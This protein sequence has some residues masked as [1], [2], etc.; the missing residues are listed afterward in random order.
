MLGAEP[1]GTLGGTTRL[2]ALA[3][4]IGSIQFVLAMAVTQLGWTS[5]YS[6]LTNYISDLGAVHC[7]YYNAA[8]DAR[9]IC[10]PWHGVFDIS[11]VILGLFSIAAAY[12]IRRAFPDRRLATLGL[13]LLAVSGFGAMGV[14]LS[15]ED[16]NLK[17]HTLSA[18]IAF[19]GGNS[20]LVVLGMSLWRDLRWNQ[21]FPVLSLVAGLVGWAG[22]LLFV[23]DAWGAFG[24]GGMERVVVAPVLLWAAVVG[25]RLIR[26]PA[27]S[28]KG[29]PPV[30]SLGMP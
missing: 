28:A 24:P 2:G 17:I 29:P 18:L 23:L 21:V 11:I 26:F 5:P 3:L 14:G 7:R 8:V 9:Y 12:L 6:L 16:V 13:V 20:A 4:L 25:A 22:L 27:A 19:V 30:S 10:S 1:V 15:P